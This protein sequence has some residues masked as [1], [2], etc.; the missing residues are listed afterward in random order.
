MIEPITNTWNHISTS[1]ETEKVVIQLKYC[2]FV[3]YLDLK[4]VQTAFS[5]GFNCTG[6]RFN[7]TGSRDVTPE[8]VKEAES[9]GYLGLD[10]EKVWQSLV[11]HELLHSL[12]S[13]YIY[14]RESLV[15]LTESGKLFSC[16]WR[17]YEEEAIVLA[18]QFY[19]NGGPTPKIL[20]Q[21]EREYP[22]GFSRLC[23]IW[24]GYYLEFLR[25]N[26][27]FKEEVT[28]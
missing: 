9:Q 18:F 7:C 12:V 4:C 23:T 27:Y 25:Q 15:L 20:Q 28:V 5:D 6:A 21:L 2:T 3:V 13:E 26:V 10:E 16:S 11:D 17:R 1:V 8:N 22:D 14:D 19:F 24:R